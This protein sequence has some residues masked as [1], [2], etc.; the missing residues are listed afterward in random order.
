MPAAPGHG[1][2]SDA[3]DGDP[4]PELVPKGKVSPGEKVWS[5]PKG[6]GRGPGREPEASGDTAPSQHTAR[7]RHKHHV[8]PLQCHR[9]LPLTHGRTWE[10]HP[11]AC[12]VL[13]ALE[14]FFDKSSKL[15]PRPSVSKHYNLSLP[16]ALITRPLQEEKPQ[17]HSSYSSGRTFIPRRRRKR[18]L[19]I[20]YLLLTSD[21]TIITSIIHTLRS[22]S[23]CPGLGK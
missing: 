11:T 15:H 16:E 13:E 14:V 3:A 6:Q 10:S 2:H 8:S 19:I 1:E 22:R 7:P 5:G 12:I 18:F 20:L 23:Y 9:E 4:R 17:T 21:Q